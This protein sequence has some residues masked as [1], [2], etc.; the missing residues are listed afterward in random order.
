MR[1][2][3]FIGLIL[4]V[5]L[6]IVAASPALLQSSA[7]GMEQLAIDWNLVDD[8]QAEYEQSLN[9]DEESQSDPDAEPAE[10]Q[11]TLKGHVLDPETGDLRDTVTESTRASNQRGR[12][13][14]GNRRVLMPG[15][16][17]NQDAYSLPPVV[18]E[19]AFLRDDA[20]CP[21]FEPWDP[22]AMWD[23]NETRGQWLA[24]AG[25]ADDPALCRQ[26]LEARVEQA[27]EGTL[28]E[29]A[30]RHRLGTLS[31]FDSERLWLELMR[32]DLF[33]SMTEVDEDRL[34]DTRADIRGRF[35]DGG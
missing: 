23:D 2:R 17:E 6:L 22:V 35:A 9:R 31:E 10:P 21:R 11:L 1:T 3:S 24:A 12:L 27:R 20:N 14:R 30:D 34:S 33:A 13:E 26:L 32:M 15:Q 8:P 19:G 5:A 4:L 7:N 29:R 18:D 25:D 16:L 28:I